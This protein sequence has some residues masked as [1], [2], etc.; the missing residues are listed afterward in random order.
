MIDA[1][2]RFLFALEDLKYFRFPASVRKSVDNSPID[3]RVALLPAV[4]L[5]QAN[6]NLLKSYPFKRGLEEGNYR[7]P[8][9]ACNRPFQIM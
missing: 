7:P 3:E 2:W 5:R 6:T 1:K 8:V 9:L 4:L